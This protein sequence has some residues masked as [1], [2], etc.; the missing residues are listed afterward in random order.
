MISGAVVPVLVDIEDLVGNPSLIEQKLP[1]T[2]AIIV[3]H[4]C[5]AADMDP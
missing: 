1:K 2:R 4:L 5:H 3:V